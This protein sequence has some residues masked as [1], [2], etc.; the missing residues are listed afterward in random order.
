LAL[1]AG[2]KVLL[3]DKI[4]L[5]D[6][7]QPQPSE[8][9]TP[10]AEIN[11]QHSHGWPVEDSCT[12]CLGA[13]ARTL[14]PAPDKILLPE[15]PQPP[16]SEI[17]KPAAGRKGRHFGGRRRGKGSRSA[18]LTTRCT[19]AFRESVVTAARDAGME[20]S[21]YMHARLGDTSR[22]LRSGTD[23]DALRKILAQMGKLGSNLNQLAHHLNSCEGR[24]LDD[25]LRAMRA[26]HAAALAKLHA[27]CA[28]IMTALG[29]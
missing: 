28:V 20:I 9:G 14:A 2:T 27:V 23:V 4:F 21:D 13:E 8:T 7:S 29:V 26:D 3:P 22:R 25:E 11:G 10:A 1:R 24:E 6:Q 16:P 19:P 15:Q 12:A 5:P 18:W 17:G